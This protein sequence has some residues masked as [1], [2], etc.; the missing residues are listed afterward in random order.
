MRVEGQGQHEFRRPVTEILAP[1]EAALG[2]LA[3]H[4]LAVELFAQR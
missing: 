3:L 1:L 2:P 4:Q